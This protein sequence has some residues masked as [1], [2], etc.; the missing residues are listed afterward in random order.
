M[1]TT[2]VNWSRVRALGRRC[3]AEEA[4]AIGAGQVWGFRALC[5]EALCTCKAS[6]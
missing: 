5:R 2:I 4:A 3:Q 1:E 6:R